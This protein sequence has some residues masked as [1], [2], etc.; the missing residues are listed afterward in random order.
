MLKIQCRRRQLLSNYWRNICKPDRF[1][2]AERF[3]A[4]KKKNH[5]TQ[6][7][8]K[9][10][11]D[12]RSAAP[13]HLF[14]SRAREFCSL[15]FAFAGFSLRLFVS[16]CCILVSCTPSCFHHKDC[17]LDCQQCFSAHSALRLQAP[18]AEANSQEK[19]LLQAVGSLL[20]QAWM[21]SQK[22][23]CSTSQPYARLPLPC[24]LQLPLPP[25][26]TQPV[27]GRAFSL[28]CLAQSGGG[29]ADGRG[30]EREMDG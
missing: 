29:K 4:G 14:D 13:T 6:G 28:R 2:L 10:P 12:G 21:R 23:A 1:T 17:N 15:G 19:V 16:C 9:K 8:C 24:Y 3:T 5:N 27:Q 20:F 26:V 11:S 18:A 30:G 25:A 22:N 7:L